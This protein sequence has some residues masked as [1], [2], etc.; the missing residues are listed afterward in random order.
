MSGSNHPPNWANA[1]VFVPSR[2]DFDPEDNY[3]GPVLDEFEG[4]DN[5]VQPL[6]VM[7]YRLP[8]EVGR[9][10]RTR[11]AQPNMPVD[12]N[13]AHALSNLYSVIM[14][15]YRDIVI[16]LGLDTD[17]QIN[18]ATQARALSANAATR[19][20]NGTEIPLFLQQYYGGN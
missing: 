18:L 5:N 2:F 17:V 14:K 9:M 15:I 19:Y 7:P 4:P 12:A 8:I 16:P 10:L 13:N 6:N 20:L 11:S 1:P 3:G